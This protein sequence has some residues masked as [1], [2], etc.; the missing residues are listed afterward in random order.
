MKK[1]KL[2]LL[3]AFMLIG[4]LGFSQQ[5][6]LLKVKNTVNTQYKIYYVYLD[7][8]TQQWATEQIAPNST[9]LVNGPQGSTLVSFKLNTQ[10]V[11][12]W[13]QFTAGVA[14]DHD[15]DDCHQCPNGD[16][17]NAGYDGVGWV[18]IKCK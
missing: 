7:G 12:T 1:I 15:I 3:L 5:T 14:A 10:C 11:T 16:G 9:H 4:M 18:G 8:G 2:L 17:A 6:T 13:V